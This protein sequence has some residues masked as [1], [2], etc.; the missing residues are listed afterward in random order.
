MSLPSEGTVADLLTKVRQMV[1]LQV[2]ESLD[3]GPSNL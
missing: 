3:H 1:P 2:L